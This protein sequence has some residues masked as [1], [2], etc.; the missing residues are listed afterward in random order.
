MNEEKSEELDKICKTDNQIK[1]NIAWITVNRNCNMRCKW[2]YAKGSEYCG[3]MSLEFAKKLAVLI[4][5]CG[6]K[7]L[8]LIGGEPTLWSH[9]FNFNKFCRKLGLETVLATNALRFSSDVFWEKYKEDPNDSVGISLKGYDELSC[10][11]IARITDFD[12]VVS[13]LR[14][15]L[16]FFQSGVSTVYNSSDPKELIDT[17]N[18]SKEIG[19]SYLSVGFCTPSITKEGSDGSFLTPINKVVASVVS[20][21]KEIS[22]IMNDKISFSMKFPLC[23]WPEDFIESLIAKKQISTL[24]QLRQ[25]TGLIFGVSGEV[26]VCNTL[27]DYP[28]GGFERD[29]S[30]REEFLKFLNT[31]LIAGY[32]NKLNN[33]PSEKCISCKKYPVCGGGCPMLWSFYKAD[34][35]IK[36]FD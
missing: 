13:G 12:S 28:I 36:G 15:G 14:R 35:V 30:A 29:F 10:K 34:K 9:L 2:C 25:K 17:A 26:I 33:Y 18:F 20:A 4:Y 23:L 32:Y 3:E 1:P 8:I 7:K 27:F 24:C 21:Y 16:D 19:A 11:K 22:C 6:I 5:D 31:P